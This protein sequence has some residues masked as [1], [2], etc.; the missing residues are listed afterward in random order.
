MPIKQATR[1]KS[2]YEVS[3][4]GVVNPVFNLDPVKSDLPLAT[5]YG[6]MPP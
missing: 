6:N 3:N 2:G 4:Y 1:G 5:K